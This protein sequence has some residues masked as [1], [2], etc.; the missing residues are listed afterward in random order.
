MSERTPNHHAGVS[1][2]DAEV[3]RMIAES[4]AA[5]ADFAQRADAEIAAQ[6]QATNHAPAQREAA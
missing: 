3:A 1:A 5:Q 2:I 4:H 6:K